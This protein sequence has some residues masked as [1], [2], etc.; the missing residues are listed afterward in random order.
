[1]DAMAQAPPQT[2]IFHGSFG[3]YREHGHHAV[4]LPGV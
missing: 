4:G 1:V 2:L 3:V